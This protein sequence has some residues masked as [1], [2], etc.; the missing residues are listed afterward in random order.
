MPERTPIPTETPTQAPDEQ[1][2]YEAD[3]AK[4]CPAQKVTITRTIA[5]I[6]P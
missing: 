4:L 1:Q 2:E 3:P 5:P 6:L